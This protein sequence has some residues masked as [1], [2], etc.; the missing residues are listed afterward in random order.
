[1]QLRTQAWPGDRGFDVL[2]DRRPAFIHGIPQHQERAA[3][4]DAGSL[5]GFWG[6]RCFFF[7]G[8][9][10]DEGDKKAEV[11]FLFGGK[12]YLQKKGRHTWVLYRLCDLLW[13]YATFRK[14]HYIA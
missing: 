3:A 9:F 10:I 7:S 5:V 8:S 4:E 11:L 6:E 2:T 1:M 13:L 12:T 14:R